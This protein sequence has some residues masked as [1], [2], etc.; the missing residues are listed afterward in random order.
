MLQKILF[1]IY[2]NNKIRVSAFS[3]IANNHKCV[4]IIRSSY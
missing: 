1:Q 4:L 2:S 3:N